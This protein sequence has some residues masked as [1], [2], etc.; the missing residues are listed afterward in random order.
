MRHQRTT[1]RRIANRGGGFTIVEL[2]VTVAIIALL[3]SLLVVAFGGMFGT[4]KE[5]ATRGTIAKVSRA[6]DD[7]L[8]DLEMALQKGAL[9]SKIDTLQKSYNLSKSAATAKIRKDEFRKAFPQS[10]EELQ[11]AAGINPP[12]PNT[13]SLADNS[14][15]LY[16]AVTS[17]TAFGAT[18]VGTD[19]F[20]A[21]EVRDTDGDGLLEFVDGWDQPLRFYRWPTRLVRPD[22]PM[23]TIDADA[24]ELVMEGLTADTLA[25]DP[26][27]P[28]AST[29]FTVSETSHHTPNTYHS[30][31]ILSSGP[32]TVLG[33]HEPADKA[34]FGHL[35]RPTAEVLSAGDPGNSSLGDDISNHQRID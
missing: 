26:D 21:T 2:L 4:A 3:A 14:E 22:G 7:R 33:L 30:P 5:A 6:V 18:A 27:Y 9:R 28:I 10:W 29:G 8:Q 12:S 1:T 20:T 16:W 13:K 34:N 32:D 19:N 24:V 15:C 31:L 17:G 25:V 23:G 11:T 35:A